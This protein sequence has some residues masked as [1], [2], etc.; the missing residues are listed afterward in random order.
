[1]GN[2]SDNL[3]ILKSTDYGK[4]WISKST[5]NTIPVT[6]DLKLFIIIIIL[7]YV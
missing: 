4:K 2:N 5:T 1:M 7:Y 6:N 3:R